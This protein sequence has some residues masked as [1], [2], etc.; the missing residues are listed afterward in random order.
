VLDEPPLS[1]VSALRDGRLEFAVAGEIDLATA[2]IFRSTIDA[3][4]HGSDGDVVIDLG[5][6]TFLGSP[7]LHALVRTQ[8]ELERDARRMVIICPPGSA[9]RIIEVCGLDGTLH[10]LASRDEL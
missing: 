7:G 2:D 3:A 9:R 8:R 6:V 5:G 1:V 10:L 4:L